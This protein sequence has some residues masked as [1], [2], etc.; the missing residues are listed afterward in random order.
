[1]D[2]EVKNEQMQ[3]LSSWIDDYTTLEGLNDYK[4]N[5]KG[6]DS[7]LIPQ[8][9]LELMQKDDLLINYTWNF[10]WTAGRGG[11]LILRH[12]KVKYY[13]DIWIS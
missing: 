9:F 13:C 11:F 6:W 4:I 12:G 2:Y 3:E 5:N 7:N 1:M 10:S 8:D